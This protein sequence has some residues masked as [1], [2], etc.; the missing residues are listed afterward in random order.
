[1]GLVGVYGCYR[2]IEIDQKC[3]RSIFGAY[4]KR[5]RRSEDDLQ[6]KE[7]LRAAQRRSEAL[8]RSSMTDLTSVEWYRWACCFCV[9]RRSGSA[10][11]DWI[12]VFGLGGEQVAV[13]ARVSMYGKFGIS[14]VS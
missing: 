8:V 1:M 14:Q 7:T 3:K 11:R 5:Y 13:T 2:Q 6:L 4:T 9:L 12:P 10:T